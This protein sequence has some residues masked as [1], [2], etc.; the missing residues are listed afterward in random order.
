MEID[1]TYHTYQLNAGGTCRA[2]DPEGM[3]ACWRKGLSILD[4]KWVLVV[5]YFHKSI[6]SSSN[7]FSPSFSSA[8]ELIN[9]FE[10]KNLLMTL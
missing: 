9:P 3:E 5:A 4:L 2:V 8:Q 6:S 7:T 10:F 1:G